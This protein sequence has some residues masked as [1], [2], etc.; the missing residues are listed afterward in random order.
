MHRLVIALVTL[1]TLT[2]VAVVGA[3]AF[4]FGASTDRAASLVPAQSAFYLNVY[5]QP[6]AGQQMNLAGLIGRLPGFADLAT[7]DDK[8]DQIAQNLLSGTGI[9]YREQIKPWLGD[10][11]AVAAW[12]TGADVAEAQSIVLAEVKD[13]DLAR[14]SVADLVADGG[15]SFTS[16]EY[17][18]VTL[19]VS[20]EASYAFV[21]EMLVVGTS[22]DALRGAVDVSNGAASLAGRSD[23]GA[24]MDALPA[25]HLA[26]AFV[27]V[28][29]LGEATNVADQMA[30]LSTAGAVLVAEPEGLR[31]SGSAPFD[32]DQAGPSARA[33]VALGSEPSSLADW[34]PSDT[35]AEAVVFGLRQTLEEAEAALGG[36]PGGEE[37]AGSLDT[38]RAL[39]AFGLG[40]D[41]D[42]DILPLL[43]REVAVAL[44]DLE[45]ELPSGQL[46]L[47]PSDPAAA[48]DALSRLSDALAGA[49]GERRTETVAGTDITVLSIPDT[50]E[51]AYA[52]VDG[53]VIIALSADD[54]GAAIE[55]HRTGK[56][57]GGSDAYSTTF[58]V[59]GTRAG[60]EVFV[61]VAALVERMGA[62]V[63]LP[64]DARDIL[65]RIG[66]FGFTAPSRS[67]QIEFHAVL[68]VLGPGAE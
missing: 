61:D 35:V 30:G 12:P 4:L 41:L 9:D 6:S 34:M 28:R 45:G 22:A 56:S 63:D 17:Q 53:I 60:N 37:V 58:E 21:G 7:L 39:A 19:Q 10:Q 68:T 47:R 38:L 15:V 1:I 59:A 64:D 42:A 66:T 8:V 54:V 5:L 46:L 43:D 32:R 62:S 44:S 40:I 52:I 23:F 16:E 11:V 55:A 36:A 3:Y 31:L 14:A 27:D 33:T 20:D 65:L 26:A 51:A 18:G 2:G 50:G 67:D 24:T 48:T 49:G 57:L 29:A 13:A 25:D